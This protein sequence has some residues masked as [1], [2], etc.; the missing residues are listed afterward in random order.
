[1]VG[2]GGSLGAVGHPEGQGRR[3]NP[4][5][6]FT[7]LWCNQILVIIKMLTKHARFPLSRLPLL[8]AL[9]STSLLLPSAFAG[10]QGQG[11]GHKSDGRQFHTFTHGGGAD[12]GSRLIH[13]IGRDERNDFFVSP[14]RPARSGGFFGRQKPGDEKVGYD[15]GGPFLNAHIDSASRSSQQTKKSRSSPGNDGLLFDTGGPFKNARFKKDKP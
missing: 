11:H 14:A 5:P 7:R 8:A 6:N 12:T 13:G 15:T 2:L 10:G 9:L 3:K 4:L 1:M